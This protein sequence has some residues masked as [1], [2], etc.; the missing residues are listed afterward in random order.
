MKKP[1]AESD[2]NSTTW[3]LVRIQHSL[4]RRIRLAI[5]YLRAFFGLPRQLLGWRE[6]RRVQRNTI[7]QLGYGS[8]KKLI[9]FFIPS[10]QRVTGGTLQIFTL[11]RLTREFFKN[12]KTDALICWLPGGG[13][14]LHH[15]D[16]FDNEV[17]IF[18]LE[19]VLR[20]CNSNCELMF[21]LPEFAAFRVL[22]RIG[23]KRLTQYREKHGLQIN[24]LNQNIEVMLDSSHLDRIKKIFP[25]LTC[26]AG[27]PA[28]AS[29]SE[30]QRL[31]IPIHVLPTWYYTDDAPWQPYE[32]KKNLMIV[33]PDTNPHRDLILGALHNALP[34]LEIQVIQGLKYEK[35]IELERAAKWSLTFG[36]GL[37]GYFYGP[38]LRGGV[39]FAVRN[40]TFDLPGLEDLKTVY[41]SYE[42]MAEH[43][44]ADI[45]AL[46]NTEAYEAYNEIVR[47]PLAHVL[48]RDRTADTL[49]AFYRNELSFP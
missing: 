25:D 11:H 45:R 12:T 13:W 36:E 7:K 10:I 1:L 22:E 18:P 4:S 29:K 49:A 3:W 35:Y 19:M 8:C 34:E 2:R 40:G 21:H 46:D 37:D 47:S 39:A 9:V 38:V 20:A 31:N 33:S 43:I 6:S 32:S 42:I 27:N 41:Q 23:W 26:T 15:F 14:D 28:W 44:A 16:G 5:S 48:G 17:T 30:R 24:I